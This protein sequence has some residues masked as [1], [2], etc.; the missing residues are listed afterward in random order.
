MNK[1]TDARAIIDPDKDHDEQSRAG[2]GA[3]IDNV[4]MRLVSRV[5]EEVKEAHERG[6]P[7]DPAAPL[8][9]MIDVL[10]DIIEARRE[11]NRLYG[12]TGDEELARAG[13]IDERAVR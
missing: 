12:A 11:L 6:E 5:L 4:L 9:H 7:Q 8:D 10:D 3:A 2:R 1:T 13:A